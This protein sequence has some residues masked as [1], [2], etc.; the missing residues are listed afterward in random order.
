MFV[1]LGCIQH[2]LP[3]AFQVFTPALHC[4]AASPLS[5]AFKAMSFALHH[6]ASTDFIPGNLLLPLCSILPGFRLSSVGNACEKQAGSE[7]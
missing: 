3:V 4:L 1:P 7:C 5:Q 2:L 6:F